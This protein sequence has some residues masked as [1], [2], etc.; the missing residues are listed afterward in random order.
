MINVLLLVPRIWRRRKKK[1]RVLLNLSTVSVNGDLWWRS[2]RGS[3]D[4]TTD[5]QPY[6]TCSI[7][8]DIMRDTHKA[9]EHLLL[10]FEKKK[11]KK[12]RGKDTPQWENTGF[13]IALRK[14]LNWEGTPHFETRMGNRSSLLISFELS[15]EKNCQNFLPP[16]PPI[17]HYFAHARLWGS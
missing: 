4:N 11:N 6:S 8:L 10:L 2:Y 13:Q 1:L 15:R 17:C 16:P 3:V 7:I 5:S 14:F 9:E 12:F